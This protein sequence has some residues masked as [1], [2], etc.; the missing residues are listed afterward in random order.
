MVSFERPQFLYELLRFILPDL[1]MV[2]QR[3]KQHEGLTNDLLPFEFMRVQKCLTFFGVICLVPYP[4]Q[5]RLRF[6][7]TPS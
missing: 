5:C 2:L 3:G 1:T 4:E 7:K 6:D